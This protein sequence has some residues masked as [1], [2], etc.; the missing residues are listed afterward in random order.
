MMK[1]DEI[2]TFLTIVDSKGILKAADHLFVSQSTVSNRLLSLEK[3]IG[4]K[5]IDR[6]PGQKELSLTKRGEEFLP[7]ARELF[8]LMHTINEWGARTPRERLRIGT[9]DSISGPLLK[10]FYRK[11]ALEKNILLEISTHWTDRLFDLLENHH[12]DIAIVPRLFHSNKIE[13]TLLFE[14][15]MVFISGDETSERVSIQELDPSK[16]IY[17]DWG[18]DFVA[19][20]GRWFDPSVRPWMIVDITEILFESLRMKNS[21]AIVPLSV[22][23]ELNKRFS[24]SKAIISETPPKRV[25]Y[26]AV[27]P[28]IPS[29]KVDAV[30]M[31]KEYLKEFVESKK[32]P[33]DH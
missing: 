4:T 17:F 33:D 22:A 2:L 23:Q 14:E 28:E 29:R 7:Y 19:W 24:F 20:H 32:T 21:W 26:L 30:Q 16:E 1:I 12:L 31:F 27:R 3:T 9:I 13:T 10:E 6:N 11:I 25:A 5:L 8:N 18:N 15:E